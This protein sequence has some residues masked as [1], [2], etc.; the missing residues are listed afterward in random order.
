MTKFFVMS[1]LQ[2][3]NDET[4]IL[5]SWSHVTMM[6][7][8]TKWYSTWNKSWVEW[9]RH[10][11]YKKLQKLGIM[12][13]RVFTKRVRR[14]IVRVLPVIRIIMDI[15]WIWIWNRDIGN[16]V[17]WWN[18]TGCKHWIYMRKWTWGAN[19]VKRHQ[20]HL[21]Y[22]DSLWTLRVSKSWFLK[23]ATGLSSNTIGD[24][25]DSN[26]ESS[27]NRRRRGG[28][29]RPSGWLENLG[30]WKW[31]GGCMADW[32]QWGGSCGLGYKWSCSEGRRHCGGGGGVG[33]LI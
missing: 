13:L 20:W 3:L 25:P 28:W 32:R 24:N 27:S 11:N 1:Q 30:S 31:R 14:S 15:W 18:W 19:E 5:S 16:W 17:F 7:N 4:I 29:S 8:W 2:V 10:Q 6:T 33:I 22:S 21:H 9:C 23:L 12:N 26:F